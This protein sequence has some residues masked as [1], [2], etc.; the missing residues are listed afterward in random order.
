MRAKSKTLAI[1]TEGILASAAYSVKIKF[2]SG[3]P[4]FRCT[5][6]PH[7]GIK[8]L[9]VYSLEAALRGISPFVVEVST[10]KK[11]NSKRE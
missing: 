5:V 7:C 2:F 3:A 4:H 8:K 6:R 11:S 9:V 10:V 1:T